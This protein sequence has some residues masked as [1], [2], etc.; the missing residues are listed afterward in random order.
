MP[1]PSDQYYDALLQGLRE[2][3]D[4]ARAE[5][6]SAYMRHQFPFWGIR[7]SPRRAMVREV[8]RRLPLL[9]DAELR[10]LVGRAWAEPEREWQYAALDLLVRYRRRLGIDWLDELETLVQAKSWWDTVDV[11]APQLIGEILRRHP[12]E[13]PPR[14]AH[15]L[16]SDNIWLQRTAL[17][18]QLKYGAETVEDWLFA[19]VTRLAGSGEFFVQKGAG[20]ALRQ[21]SRVAPERV[22]TFVASQ[23]LAPLTVREGTKHCGIST[24]TGSGSK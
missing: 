10:R 22:R 3:A 2:L 16:E 14:L 7:A 12:E 17:I 23:K 5:P 13:V 9:S 8:D 19:A 6:M 24:D 15:W 20:W 21:Y 11:L 18:F 4:P 1:D